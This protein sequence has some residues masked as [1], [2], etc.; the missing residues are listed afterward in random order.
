MI[1]DTVTSTLRKQSTN[2]LFM[3]QAAF[4]GVIDIRVSKICRRLTINLNIDIVLIYNFKAFR[5]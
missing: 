5:S 4:M 2:H 1:A 3:I